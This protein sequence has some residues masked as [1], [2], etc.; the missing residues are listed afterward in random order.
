M[1]CAIAPWLPVPHANRILTPAFHKASKWYGPLQVKT[2]D[3]LHKDGPQIALYILAELAV[4]DAIRVVQD[5]WS[6]PAAELDLCRIMTQLI[7]GPGLIS[8][9]PDRIFGF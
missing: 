3:G 5:E 2:I 9:R 7:D 1:I 8:H 4:S 6:I